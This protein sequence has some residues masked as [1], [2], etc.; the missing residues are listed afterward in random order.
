MLDLFHVAAI[1]L[2]VGLSTYSYDGRFSGFGYRP[3]TTFFDCTQGEVIV[4]RSGTY[5]LDPVVRAQE[6]AK[7]SSRFSVGFLLGNKEY[8]Q[9]LPEGT[10]RPAR[11]GIFIIN[12]SDYGHDARGNFEVFTRAVEFPIVDLAIILVG[13]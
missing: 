5:W 9:L 7:A 3:V 12:S 8:P 2:S 1:V 13:L 11:A 6:D 4:G 10:R